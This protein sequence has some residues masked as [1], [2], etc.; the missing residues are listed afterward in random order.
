MP[1]LRLKLL[2]FFRVQ[3]DKHHCACRDTMDMDSMPPPPPPKDSYHFGYHT[4]SSRDKPLPNQGSSSSFSSHGI[5]PPPP[6]KATQSH[7]VST[8]P[9]YPYP[10]RRN[11][12]EPAEAHEYID[13]LQEEAQR[14]ARLKLEREIARLQEAAEEEQR[15][16]A[17]EAE[18]H[19]ASRVRRQRE[20]QER[21][22]E[23]EKRLELETRRR[24]EK[25]KRIAEAK[26]L[27]EWR[28]EQAKRAE[29][30]AVSKVETR[31]RREEER[32][33]RILSSSSSRPNNVDVVAGWV[34]L[35][36]GDSLM[37]KRR[38]CSIR[39]QGVRFFKD[40]SASQFLE[41]IEAVDI[42]KVSDN[43]DEIYGLETL[44]YAF[45]IQT[46]DGKTSIIIP[47][48][49]HQ[50]EDFISAVIQVAGL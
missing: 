19:Y 18:L 31:K 22:E 15:R 10:R 4:M 37:S 9:L 36:A 28:I 40:A 1:N 21:E 41:S 14:Q 11:V 43:E 29:E 47:E 46:R 8:V 23:E 7:M 48:V 38:Y 20:A 5:P 49:S 25:E 45:G 30:L 12:S 24:I 42:A 33:K 13:T 6:V 44:Q 50:T 35:Q 27:Q 39:E 32:R 16:K 17:L 3:L 26:K 2:T 34:T